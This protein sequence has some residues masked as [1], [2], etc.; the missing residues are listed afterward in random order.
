MTQLILVRHGQTAWNRKPRFRGQYDIELDEVGLA[1]ALATADKLARFPI[2]AV[3]SSPLKRA[4]A[5]A[6]PIADVFGLSVQPHNGLM[7]INFGKC[8]GLTPDEVRVRYGDLVD[9]WLQ[10]P[11]TVTFPD[12]ECLNDVGSR[13]N[14]AL[15]ELTA[16]HNGQTIALISHVVALK[17]ALCMILGLDNSHFWLVAQDNCAINIVNA[18]DGAYT[19]KL[20]NDTC[21]L[22]R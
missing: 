5:T 8:Q 2:A 19:I 10:K 1:Q 20:I 3:Y 6:Q 18:K 7:D 13:F 9:N 14:Q 15:N 16:K 22:D 11:Q 4:L 17:V 21:H 12:G